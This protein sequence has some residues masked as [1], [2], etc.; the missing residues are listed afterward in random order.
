MT[1]W[2]KFSLSQ[3][4]VLAV[5]QN[6]TCNAPYASRISLGFA[7]DLADQD[8][9]FREA[10]DVLR[11]IDALE[12]IIPPPSTKPAEHFKHPPLHPFWHKHFCTSRHFMTNLG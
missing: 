8:R 12:G 5:K 6:V 7:C 9:R 10:P 4:Q 1:E 11:E 2:V 3:G